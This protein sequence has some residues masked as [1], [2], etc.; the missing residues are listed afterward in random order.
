MIVWCG[1]DLHDILPYGCR[2]FAAICVPTPYMIS[3]LCSCRESLRDEW[4][5]VQELT[6]IMEPLA[7]GMVRGEVRKHQ[8]CLSCA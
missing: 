6:K 5:L 2:V 4:Y 7:L 8:H 1:D 3:W